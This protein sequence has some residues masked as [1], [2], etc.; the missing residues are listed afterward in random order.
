MRPT[1]EFGLVE[2]RPFLVTRMGYCSSDKTS[3]TYNLV[4]QMQFLYVNVVKARDLPSMDIIGS[5]DPSVEVKHGNYKG[6][7]KHLEKNQNPFCN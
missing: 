3:T 1:L 2:T 6:V 7:T 4:E 5:L